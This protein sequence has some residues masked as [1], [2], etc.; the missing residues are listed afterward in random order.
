M[1]KED[2]DLLIKLS[3]KMDQLCKTT[4]QNSKDNIEAHKEII[5]K[6]DSNFKTTTTWV[7]NVHER[8]DD[9]I[10]GT[11][12]RVEKYNEAFIQS[13]VFYWVVGFIIAGIVS[14][15]GTI[16]YLGKEFD[17]RVDKVETSVEKVE[18]TVH[19]YHP[20]ILELNKE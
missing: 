20:D 12:E 19:K 9:Q 8:I 15:W 2:R 14:A 3:T 7:E 11:A 6:I 1:D 4:N 18:E 17:N 10:K 5:Q 16:S 13:K